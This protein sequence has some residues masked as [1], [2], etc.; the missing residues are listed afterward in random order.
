MVGGGGWLWVGGV[1]TFIVFSFDQAEQMQPHSLKCSTVQRGVVS[2][3]IFANVW[4]W[5][6]TEM[7]VDYQTNR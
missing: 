7:S 4:L 6:Y 5:C 3:G 1:K 2:D